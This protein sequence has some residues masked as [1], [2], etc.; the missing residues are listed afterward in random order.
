MKNIISQLIDDYHERKLPELVI[1]NKKLPEIKGKADVVTGMRRSGK[2]WF[3]YQKMKELIASG[4][5]KEEI[6]YLNFEDDRLLNFNVNNF[7]EI[8]DVYFG[9]YPEHRNIRCNFFLMRYSE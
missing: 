1:R 9:K 6:L 7:Q 2:T 8:L 5:K 3:C 4:I